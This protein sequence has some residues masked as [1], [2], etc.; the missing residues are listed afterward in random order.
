VG[1]LPAGTGAVA[2]DVQSK[3]RESVSIKD[4][5]PSDFDYLTDDTT[6]YIL[7][8]ITYAN[9]S[10]I[11]F[12]AETYRIKTDLTISVSHTSLIGKGYQTTSGSAVTLLTLDDGVTIKTSGTDAVVGARHITIENMRIERASGSVSAE[13]VVQLL[14]CPDAKL[15][16]VF[17]S[18]LQTTDAV[19]LRIRYSWNVLLS[20]V[21][22]WTAY[23]GLD[24][25]KATNQLRAENLNING[26]AIG[27]AGG[28]NTLTL[29][30]P[31]IQQYTVAG[32]KLGWN[33]TAGGGA[34]TPESTTSPSIIDGYFETETAGAREVDLGA[35]TWVR[36]PI[37]RGNYYAHVTNNGTQSP[38]LLK[39][40]YGY[41]VSHNFWTGY[42]TTTAVEFNYVTAGGGYFPSNGFIGYNNS[43]YTAPGTQLAWGA[44]TTETQKYA[45]F[46]NESN[47]VKN[48][49]EREIGRT[50][51]VRSAP[52][53]FVSGGPTTF[54]IPIMR[55][56]HYGRINAIRVLCSD[57]L[58]STT[59]FTLT[60]G[61]V[62]TPGYYTTVSVA[63]WSSGSI[64][65]ATL[66]NSR[67]QNDNRL[68]YAV[69]TNNDTLSAEGNIVV[70]IE[71]NDVVE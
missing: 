53:T 41:D 45:L 25:D 43:L 49:N 39:Q 66:S 8:A 70:E 61:I 35:D 20:D 24:G 11:N 33:Y 4:F 59:T 56:E 46:T 36:N 13:P 6:P 5:L 18:P 50:R 69:L 28:F 42:T 44:G 40:V 10:E 54:S 2:T 37:V 32:V 21:W 12:D 15:R 14:G 67:I 1:Y 60:V 63:G 3:L 27:V 65:A 23:V 16:G 71:Y 58:T 17:I 68:I 9:G 7:A 31:V 64:T 51:F 55:G 26:C 22:L 52:I 62:G 48:W 57:G 38:V 47:I 19:A 30:R 34:V 29:V